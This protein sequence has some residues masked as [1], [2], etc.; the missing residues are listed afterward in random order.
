MDE[1]FKFAGIAVLVI[2]GIL[3]ISKG[4]IKA[5]PDVAYIISGLRKK[6]KILIGRAGIRIPFLERVDKLLVRQISIDIKSE[7][8]IPT[9]DFIGVDVDSVAKFRVMTDAEG[10]EKA[11][12][13][14]LNMNAQTFEAAIR[15]SLQGNM[16]EIIGTITLKEI[17]N[18]RKKFGDE[19]QAKAQ[20]DMNA[21][22]VEIISCNIQRVTDE[23][24]LINAL[25]QD[26]M[27]KIQKDAAIAKAEADR[28]VSIAQAAA[29]REANEAKVRASTEIAIKQNELAIKE[30]ELK[31]ASDTKKA[32]ADAAYQI[33]EETQRKTIEITAADADIARR[34]KE[35]ELAEKE[36]KLQERKLDA[37]IR[38]KADAEKYAAEKKA[39]AELITRQ[40][41]AEAKRYEQEQ[42]AAGI[43]AV[44]EAEAEAIR[45]KAIAEA[46]GIDKK[47]EAMRKYGDAAI[48]EIIMTALPEIAKNVAEPLSKVD[49][50]TMYGE[51]NSNK[52]ISDIVNTT[53][54]VSEG[55]TSSM[56]IDLKALLSGLLG[57]RM[58]TIPAGQPQ[59][60]K[61]AELA[62]AKPEA[63]TT[64]HKD[65]GV[66]PSEATE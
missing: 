32:M 33:Q 47:A 43:R 15:D 11:M 49:K 36:I 25:G 1:I 51:G 45:Q 34:E 24:E 14:F 4:Y 31:S 2:L 42:A 19:V 12:R 41:E 7:G 61:P 46:E 60:V 62:D 16:R 13:N 40:K 63:D 56:G 52:L 55:L 27:S 65:D 10:I 38:K 50:I 37:E 48:I 44:G 21:L 3:I 66:E 8:F 17:C 57:G 54:Q 30:A 39:E 26:N 29:E 64:D 5:P 59:M 9:Q 35:A 20:T 22:G 53:T 23:K 28:D 18:D 6:P 58:A